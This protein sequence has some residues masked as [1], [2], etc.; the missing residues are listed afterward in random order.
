MPAPKSTRGYGA[1]ACSPR[2]TSDRR[3]RVGP[4]GLQV[5]WPKIA[6]RGRRRRR[7]TV[8]FR[9]ADAPPPADAVVALGGCRDRAHAVGESGGVPQQ[10]SAVVVAD[11]GFEYSAALPCFLRG[12]DRF[13]VPR[14]GTPVPFEGLVADCVINLAGSGVSVVASVCD[15]DLGV[16]TIG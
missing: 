3:I 16:I 12:E 1:T 6:G 5:P 14:P 8:L 4:R 13:G 7:Q 2:E 15:H 11:I 10:P 9:G